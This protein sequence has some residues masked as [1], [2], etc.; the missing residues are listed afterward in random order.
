M[1]Q[2]KDIE[3]LQSFNNGQKI[4]LK[5]LLIVPCCVVGFGILLHIDKINTQTESEAFKNS[6]VLVCYETLIVSDSNWKLVDRYLINNNSAGYI[7]IDN[8][9][10]K[11]D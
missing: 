11:K 8:C 5:I 6:E 3:D 1:K 2:D 4:L 7:L 10:I 9:R